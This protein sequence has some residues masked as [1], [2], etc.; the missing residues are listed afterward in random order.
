MDQK[1]IVSNVIFNAS[2]SLRSASLC[3]IR[4]LASCKLSF[5][6]VPWQ[7]RLT[8]TA[9]APTSAADNGNVYVYSP[10]Q[11]EKTLTLAGAF[12]DVA[13]LASGPYTFLANPS[14][15]NVISTCNNAVAPNAPTSLPPLL[16]G[17]V[18]NANQIVAANTSGIDV[19]TA[20]I[21]DDT[22]GQCPPPI[23]FADQAINFG[24]GTLN[25]RKLIVASDGC[26][27]RGTGSRAATRPCRQFLE[28]DRALFRWPLE[29]LKP[30]L[31]T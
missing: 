18:K 19:I 20:T 14:G 16:L 6:Q 10:F 2:A 27:H 26:P 21:P 29:A 12:T 15:L 25:P 17:G 22:G 23:S 24:L 31:E 5:F 30:C 9:S 7:P 13:P 8:M 28:P 11:T 1:V 3:S 4:R